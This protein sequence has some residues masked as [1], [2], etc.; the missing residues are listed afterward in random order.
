MRHPDGLIE[1]VY[2]LA[3]Q[4][5]RCNC[6]T[7]TKDLA[8]NGLYL[9][10]E[11]GET[12]IHRGDVS[13]RIVRVGIN[14]A[15]GRFPKR[16]R[17]H[18]RNNK[19]RSAFRR[20]LGGA[21]LAQDDPAD[22]RF[23]EWVASKGHRD[24]AVE[25]RVSAVLRDRFTYSYVAIESK[26]DRRDLERGLIALLAKHANQRSDRWL[27]QWAVSD[28]IRRSS[29]WNSVHVDAQPLSEDGLEVLERSVAAT[30][31]AR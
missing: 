7:P 15:Q 13:H 22:P 25:A 3:S 8:A 26:S 12:I 28:A 30:L 21:L 6:E 16:V 2:D 18:F 14:T 20:H 4:L 19:N 5:P 31:E 27:G 17:E 11:T 10:F 24:R 9:F 29:L 1:A 23:P